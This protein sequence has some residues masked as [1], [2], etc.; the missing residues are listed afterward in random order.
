MALPDR[1][2]LTVKQVAKQLKVGV[3]TVWRWVSQGIFPE[4]IR[5][6]PQTIRWNPEDI[7]RLLQ[8]RRRTK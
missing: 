2:L 3:R 1:E 6:S 4:P 8:E 5:I 7:E